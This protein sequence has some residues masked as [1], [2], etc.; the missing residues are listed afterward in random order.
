MTTKLLKNNSTYKVRSAKPVDGDT[1]DI[2]IDAGLSHP[3][4]ERLNLLGL[5]A[6]EL[7]DPSSHA[8]E[9]AESTKIRIQELLDQSTETTIRVNQV[10]G[11]NVIDLLVKINGERISVSDKLIEEGHNKE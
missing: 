7:N 8:R 6:E 2:H 5:D 10:K 1:V 3:L 11:R 9:K 4:F